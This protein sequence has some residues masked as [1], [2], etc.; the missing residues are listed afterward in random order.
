MLDLR[1]LIF[2]F[3]WRIFL[4]GVILLKVF[5]FLYSFF[6]KKR[7]RFTFSRITH[8]KPDVH[9]ELVMASTRIVERLDPIEYRALMTA[10]RDRIC[11]SEHALVRFSEKQRNI[12]KDDHIIRLLMQENPRLVGLQENGRHAAFF[13]RDTGYLRIVFAVHEDVIEIVTVCINNE[14]PRI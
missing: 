13:R 5:S 14:L 12:Y 8:V 6:R 9:E 3:L 1:M 10:Y 7:N 2:F 4:K 11:V